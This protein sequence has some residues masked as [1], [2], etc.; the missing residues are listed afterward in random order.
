MTMIG[1][2]STT[3]NFK[4]LWKYANDQIG[5]MWDSN[6]PSRITI[7]EGVSKIRFI[8]YCN[9]SPISNIGKHHFR[10]YK[11][12]ENYIYLGYI[13]CTVPNNPAGAGV[14]YS[15]EVFQTNAGDYYELYVLPQSYN[16]YNATSVATGHSLS[17]EICN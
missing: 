11:N 7:P 8:A 16:Q 10:I 17:I 4:C 6:N 14:I 2:A 12:G 13:S 1:S 3:S 5:E 9:S 15:T